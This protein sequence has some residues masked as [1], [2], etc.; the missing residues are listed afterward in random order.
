M[1][2]PKFIQKVL[3]KQSV[4]VFEIGDIERMRAYQQNLV[5]FLLYQPPK[6]PAGGTNHLSHAKIH[7]E[8]KDIEIWLKS[9]TKDFALNNL[10]TFQL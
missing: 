3:R 4:P 6:Y 7:Q 10:R 8:I 5:S 9:T 1:S 2:E